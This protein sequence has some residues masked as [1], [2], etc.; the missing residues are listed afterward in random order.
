MIKL[1]ATDLD[2]T[3][4]DRSRNISAED[5]AAVKTAFEEG[6]HF[7]VASGR[8]NAEIVQLMTEYEGRYFTVGQNGAT[9][10]SKEKELVYHAAF[11]PQIAAQIM[12]TG[13][14]A[15]HLNHFVHCA[16]D[17]YYTEER[18]AETQ[19]IEA[20]IMTG[21]T[22]NA[23]LVQD[24]ES[25]EL[26]S[27]KISFFGEWETL[28]R[29]QDNLREQFPGKLE[30][31]TSERDVLDIMPLN[32]SKGTGLQHLLDTLGLEPQEI[33]CI[34]DSFNDLPMFAL[35]G[36]SYVM[37]GAHPDVKKQANH[38]VRSVA[39]AIEHIHAYNREQR[40]CGC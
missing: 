34:G 19:P 14:A 39:E 29:L 40:A 37:A 33:A 25:G 1:I 24:L 8:M 7:C 18:N 21:C 22:G 12:R 5:W 35:T 10:Y 11:E 4:L 27:C 30:T 15:G 23:R 28:L 3:L 38:V 36:H 6:Y 20:R 16:D 32:V 26:I 2:G 17:S 31:F 9:I 13:K